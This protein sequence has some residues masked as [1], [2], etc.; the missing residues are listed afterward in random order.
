[1]TTEEM[2][3]EIRQG[4]K[5]FTAELIEALVD[6]Y[7]SFDPYGVMEE[8]GDISIKYRRD[9]MKKDI[10]YILRTDPTHVIADLQED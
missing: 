1:M 2:V 10:R 8:Y 6:F 7:D 3:A 9:R 5:R 4:K